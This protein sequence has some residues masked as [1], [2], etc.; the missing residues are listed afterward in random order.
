MIT[1]LDFKNLDLFGPVV[2]RP[3]FNNFEAINAT[4]AWSLFFTGG[5][6]D[7]TL[8]FS[9]EAGRF[10]STILLAIAASGIAGVLIFQTVFPG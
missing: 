1:D 10:F 7:K 8:G 2:F 3:A 6:E 5:Q 4:Q 9:P